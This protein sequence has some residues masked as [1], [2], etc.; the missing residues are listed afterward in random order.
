MMKMANEIARRVQDE[1][2]KEARGERSTKI[3]GFWERGDRDVEA[4]PAYEA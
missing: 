3:G 2:D 4:P 1:K